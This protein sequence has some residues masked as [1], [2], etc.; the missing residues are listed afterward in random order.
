[1]SQT[2]YITSQRKVGNS[3]ISKIDRWINME[4]IGAGKYN[5]Y[6]D[7]NFPHGF[8]RSGVFTIREAEYLESHGHTLRELE[9][10]IRTPENEDEKHFQQAVCEG[11]ESQSF[12]VKAWSKYKQAITARSQRIFLSRHDGASSFLSTD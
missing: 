12:A 6:D 7:Q 10:K 4:N 3:F 11:L 5:Y 9:S 1:M 2:V 8:R